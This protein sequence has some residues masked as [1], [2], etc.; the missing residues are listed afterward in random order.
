MVESPP[1]LVSRVVLVSYCIVWVFVPD[2]MCISHHSLIGSL[3]APK[4]SVR[5][6]IKKSSNHI[7][8]AWLAL[9]KSMRTD[10]VVVELFERVP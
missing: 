2:I 8:P 9:S 7:V 4:M 10:D 3:P 1:G 5:S 6:S